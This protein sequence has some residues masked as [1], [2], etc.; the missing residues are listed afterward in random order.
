MDWYIVMMTRQFCFW[1]LLMYRDRSC[2]SFWS[3]KVLGDWI[4]AHN[5]ATLQCNEIMIHVLFQILNEK[6]FLQ[7]NDV[8]TNHTAS[9]M[10]YI[11]RFL[12]INL[13]VRIYLWRCYAPVIQLLITRLFAYCCASVSDTGR[14]IE[15]VEIC[16]WIDVLRRNVIYRSS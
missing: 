13:F 15:N 3:L 7:L 2:S 11:N 9:I 8:T 1:Q 16:I 4:L 12:L 5:K 14:N 6:P 10:S